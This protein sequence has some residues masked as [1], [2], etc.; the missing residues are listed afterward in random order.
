MIYDDTGTILTALHIVNGAKKIEVTFW[1]GDKSDATIQLKQAE[2]DIA[3]LRPDLPP[4]NL[5]R[6]RSAT[7]T[8][9][10]PAI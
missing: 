7:P 4:D 1:N 3:V 5:I 6:Q 10:D 8:R 2:N 9:C